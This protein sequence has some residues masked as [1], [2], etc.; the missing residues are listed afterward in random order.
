MYSKPTNIYQL[1][2][3]NTNARKKRDIFSKLTTKL[4]KEASQLTFLLVSLLL[5]LNKGRQMSR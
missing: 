5:T 4:H 2:F 1:N 3:N